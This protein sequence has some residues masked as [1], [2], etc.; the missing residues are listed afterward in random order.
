MI[1]VGSRNR[2]PKSGA[3]VWKDGQD[4]RAT[5]RAV[6]TARADRVRSGAFGVST[7]AG[8]HVEEVGER[9]VDVFGA[10][11]RGRPVRNEAGDGQ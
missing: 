2:S 3:S 11:D 5:G 4:A 10:L 8:Q 7:E 1:K 6:R 9:D